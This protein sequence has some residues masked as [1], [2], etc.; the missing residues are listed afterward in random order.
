MRNIVSVLVVVALVGTAS[1]G[2]RKIAV[3]GLEIAGKVD[4]AT[5]TAAQELT[6]AIRTRA[7]NGDGPFAL[8]PGSERELLDE[9]ILNDCANEAPACLALISASLA[10]DMLLYGKLEA[11]GASYQVTVRLFDVATKSIT[12]TYAQTLPATAKGAELQA[13]AKTGYAKLVEPTS[14]APPTP[15]GPPVPGCDFDALLQKGDQ[16]SGLGN[17]AAALVTYDQALKCKAEPKVVMRAF[18]ASCNARNTVNAKRFYKQLP[19][20]RQPV[21]L[22][23]C[24][25]NGIDPTP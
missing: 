15:L 3:L 11:K 7:K 24:L 17:H 8:A 16:H 13:A 2:K 14:K 25:R 12:T 22:Q 6:T 21:V 18:M 10:A 19:P 9:K 5:L 1:A 4:A 20:D 23:I